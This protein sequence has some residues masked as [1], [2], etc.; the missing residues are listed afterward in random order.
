MATTK[1]RVVTPTR[2]RKPVSTPTRTKKPTSRSKVRRTKSS[3][4]KF[5]TRLLIA[6]LAVCV[7]CI[8]CIVLIKVATMPLDTSTDEVKGLTAY[9]IVVNDETEALPTAQPKVTE[10]VETYESGEAAAPTE[11]SVVTAEDN[12]ETT[13]EQPITTQ[14][15]DVD[16]PE[17]IVMKTTSDYFLLDF[18]QTE[19][20]D[21]VKVTA[22]SDGYKVYYQENPEATKYYYIFQR[23]NSPLNTALYEG[24]ET[25]MEEEVDGAYVYVF[26]QPA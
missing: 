11:D 14:V 26:R 18:L 7:V 17:T 10:E 12:E 3:K 8:M 5:W 6:S 25:V 13:E 9:P 23:C 2:T 20:I 24:F 16:D 21:L 1:K 22:S 19:R 15:A 4:R